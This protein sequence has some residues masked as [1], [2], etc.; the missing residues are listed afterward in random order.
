[1]LD[2]A[3]G[4]PKHPIATCEMQAYVYA[5]KRDVAELF[6]AWGDHERAMRL[7][8]EATDLQRRFMERFWL[9][10]ERTVAFALD[11]DKRPLGTATSNPGHCLWSGILGGNRVQPVV[12]RLMRADLFTGFGLRTLSSDHP[13]YDPHSYQRGSVW[14]HDTIIAAAGMRRYG[15]DEEAWRLIDGILE[16]ASA[17]D[18]FQLPELFAGLQRQ[19]LDAPVPYEHA[20]VPQAWA[21]GSVFHAVRILLGLEPDI[22]NGRLYLNPALPPWCR[23]LVLDNLRVGGQR[24]T[25]EARRRSDGASAFEVRGHLGPLQVVHGPPPWWRTEE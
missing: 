16:A 18:G 9:P 14:P 12:D 5:A 20:N 6:A 25:V 19:P 3:G 1:V 4:F 15:R 22:P 23:E 10:E 13:S 21:A 24:I 11:G 8:R 17:L 7:R 2:E